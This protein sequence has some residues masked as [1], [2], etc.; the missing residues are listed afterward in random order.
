MQG[1][2]RW[3][4]RILLQGLSIL[5]PIAVAI[6]ILAWLLQGAE[7]LT[8]TL[9]V[10]VFPWQIYVPGMGVLL[11]LTAV[12]LVGLLMYPWVSDRLDGVL[13]RVPLFG[14]LYG[15][16]R[17]LMR[18]FSADARD[19]LGYPVMVRMP[20]SDFETLGFVTQKDGGSLPDGLLQPGYVVVYVQLA[21]QIGG[22]TLAVPESSCRPLDISTEEA[23]RFAI[24]AG[25]SSPRQK[26]GRAEPDHQS[27][28]RPS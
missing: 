16:V 17:D 5:V 9:T 22:L 6:Q 23:L 20:G 8:M 14:A 27:I 28:G 12:F 10:D 25:V 26:G 19:R 7:R 3:V 4:G 24:T 1:T 18:L 21:S 15:P 11:L 2:K 13:R